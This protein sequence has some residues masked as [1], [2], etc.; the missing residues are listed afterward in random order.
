MDSPD[1]SIGHGRIDH[2]RLIAHH[3][4]VGGAGQG[5][6]IGQ[7]IEKD[8]LHVVEWQRYGA[9]QMIQLLR[10]AGIVGGRVGAGEGLAV[11]L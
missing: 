8:P 7:L 5:S 3:E 4:P 11:R 10:R 9:T 2:Q 6:D 1:G